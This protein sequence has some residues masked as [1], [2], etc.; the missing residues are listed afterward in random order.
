MRLQLI[1]CS[2]LLCSAEQQSG[3]EQGHVEQSSVT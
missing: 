3:T 2:V 1:C